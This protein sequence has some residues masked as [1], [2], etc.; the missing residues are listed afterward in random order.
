[1]A[2]TI[3]QKAEAFKRLLN[4]MDDLRE[5]CP[6]DRKQT[7]KSLRNLTI[8]E[9]HELADAILENDLKGLQEE[10]GD[11]LLH[12]I[13]YAKIADEQGAFDIADVIHSLCEKLIRRHPHIY[14]D[15]QVND[16]DDVKRNWEQIKLTEGKKKVL[17]G[18]PASL[19]AMLK[20]WRMQEKVAKVGF[21]WDHPEQ[22]WEKVMEEIGEFRETIDQDLPFDK[23][24]DEFGDVLFALVN[25]ARF[26]G[27][28]PESALERTNRK[29]K[30]RYEYIESN[31][32]KPL[33]EMNL[34]EMDA[35]WVEAKA[36]E[37]K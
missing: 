36:L 14:G 33:S 13:F 31:A 1:M 30:S 24:E 17:G 27:I 25:Y 9:T 23:K 22:V 6:W 32:P 15:V 11:V 8:E 18:V 7:I 2:H 20:A 10:S 4:I 19:P 37:R 16:E 35:L 28:D 34:A 21:D 26:Q 12:L 5:K 29:F 3:E